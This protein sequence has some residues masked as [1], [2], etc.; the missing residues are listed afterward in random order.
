MRHGLTSHSSST[1]VPP[2]RRR[3]TWDA[4]CSGPRPSGAIWNLAWTRSNDDG[5][6]LAREEVVLHECDVAKVFRIHELPGGVQHRV[7]DVCPHDLSVGPDPLAQQSQPADRAA[8][9]VEDTRSATFA[10]LV[11]KAA[12]TRLPHARL[13]LKPLQLRGLI[14]QEVRVR[15]HP[16]APFEAGPTGGTQ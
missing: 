10:D 15:G 3:R 16:R 8:A 9:D 4:T 1:T 12:T 2:G 7:V 14:R 5:L 6:E 13:E 11:E